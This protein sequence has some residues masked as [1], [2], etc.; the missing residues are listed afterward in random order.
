MFR[1]CLGVPDLSRFAHLCSGAAVCLRIGCQTLALLL[2]VYTKKSLAAGVPPWTPLGELRTLPQA[3]TSDPQLLVPVALAPY[4]SH[5]WRSSLIAVPTV[6][7]PYAAPYVVDDVIYIYLY[8]YR[9]GSNY[10]KKRK[11]T[12]KARHKY[13]TAHTSK[14]QSNTQ[15]SRQTIYRKDYQPW[16]SLS[17]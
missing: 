8:F 10:S 2:P 14:Q 16:L 17:L 15:T 7:S 9:K 13:T 4:D 11:I 12:D 5:V 6:W 1:F 3:P